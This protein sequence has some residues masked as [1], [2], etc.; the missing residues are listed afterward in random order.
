MLDILKEMA[1]I[2]PREGA[3]FA[4]LL[5]GA[6]TEGI[7]D[8][9]I[10]IVAFAPNPEVQARTDTLERLGNSVQVIILEGEDV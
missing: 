7:A 3:S 6:I 8:T 5:D 2:T 1:C 4:S 9:E 10:V